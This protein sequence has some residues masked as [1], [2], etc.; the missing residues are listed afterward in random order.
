MTPEDIDRAI[1]AASPE[2][3][4]I[5]ETLYGT[6][7]RVSELC[8]LTWGDVNLETATVRL[9]GKKGDERAVPLGR[10]AHN[11][12]SAIVAGY[13]ATPGPTDRSQSQ[14]RPAAKAANGR[15]AA[16]NSNAP[17]LRS[18]LTSIPPRSETPHP[19]G[20]IN[21]DTL[22]LMRVPRCCGSRTD[23]RP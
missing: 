9:Q 8:K 21:T 5:L 6:G 7:C 14:S 11:A 4:A 13:N 15:R 19:W 2:T 18:F 10:K 12:L 1:R 22:F 16:A 3:A 23:P 17:T 20:S